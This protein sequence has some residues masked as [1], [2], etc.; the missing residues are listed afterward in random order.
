MTALLSAQFSRLW[1]TRAFWIMIGA[2]AVL[3][4][5]L[6]GVNYSP[7]IQSSSRPLVLDDEFFTFFQFSGFMSAA[8]ISLFLGTEYAD[9]T[10]RNKLIA[11]HKRRNIYFSGL[12]VC[13]TACFAALCTHLLVGGIAGY[14]IFGGFKMGL[15]RASYAILCIFLLTAV[16]AAF[17]TAVACNCQNR[18]TTAII[19]LLSVM[20]EMTAVGIL[21]G[22]LRDTAMQ[23]G[24]P[25]VRGIAFTLYQLLPCGQLQQIFM[26][27]FDYHAYWP[28]LSAGMLVLISL[29]GCTAFSKKDIK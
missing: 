28:W 19:T 12:I 8:F 2:T 23:D 10:L 20:G 27:D 14:L 7:E 25:W 13:I 21:S 9:S 26:L 11:G 1:K 4:L 16:Y 6:C 3:S 17:C 15:S 29:I 18:T 5:W 24:I 22:H